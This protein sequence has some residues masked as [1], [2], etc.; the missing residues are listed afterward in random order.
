MIF[1]RETFAIGILDKKTK[2]LQ[3][4]TGNMDL[5]SKLDRGISSTEILKR[6][7]IRPTKL[8]LFSPICILLSLASVLV[9]GILYL[10]LTTFPLVFESTYGFSSGLSG[11]AYIGLGVG[12]VLGLLV[13]TFTS[14][15]Y[16]QKRAAQG[17]L[18]PE[19]RLPLLLVSTIVSGTGL[20]W[21]GWSAKA[22]THWIV[23]IIGSS[24]VGVGNML[25]FMPVLGYL[26]DSFTLY[27]ASAMAANTVLRSIGGA[28]LP[29]A[30]PKMYASLGYGWGNSVLGFLAIAF[31]PAL[32]V[33]YRH[34]KY[35]RTRWP[36][37]LG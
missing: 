9:Y 26:V 8:S 1:A 22:H 6:A 5:R 11:L 17:L 12:N 18:Q 13:F 34:G 32:F 2:R 16:I 21:Y 28:L 25:F 19:D 29:L 10:I 15:K 35:I 36:V 33:I 20:F 27:A 31:T 14:D 30:G 24:L 7:I 3:K 4:E 23:P 37:N